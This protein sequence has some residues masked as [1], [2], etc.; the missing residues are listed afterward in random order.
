MANRPSGPYDPVRRPQQIDTGT[1]ALTCTPI[2]GPTGQPG[3]KA[4]WS[5]V[6][7]LLPKPQYKFEYRASCEDLTSRTKAKKNVRRISPTLALQGSGVYIH[8][9]SEVAVFKEDVNVTKRSAT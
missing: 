7:A 2:C 9:N 4:P 6:D 1:L 8:V 3:P 5:E